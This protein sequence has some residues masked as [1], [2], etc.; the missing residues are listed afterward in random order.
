MAKQESQ[1]RWPQAQEAQWNVELSSQAQ[2]PK[3]G[4]FSRHHFTW[5]RSRTARLGETE[6]QN[7]LTWKGLIGIMEWNSLPCTGQQDG[8]GG[9]DPLL[10]R[11][12]ALKQLPSK[13]LTSCLR[14]LWI[15]LKTPYMQSNRKPSIWLQEPGF[16]YSEQK[17]SW[18]FFLPSSS[19]PI[20]ITCFPPTFSPWILNQF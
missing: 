12:L 7:V 16:L 19:D 5:P 8:P 4:L 10:P 18:V 9:C 1:L 17:G 6:S 11:H 2:R 15:P 3:T 14:E 13:V 20:N